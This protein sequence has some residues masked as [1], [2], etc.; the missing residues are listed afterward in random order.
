MAAFCP[1]RWPKQK[2]RWNNS[3]LLLIEIIGSSSRAL[4]LGPGPLRSGRDSFPFI[5]LKCC[6]RLVGNAVGTRTGAGNKPSNVSGL[7]S[8]FL[9]RDHAIRV[10][11][12]GE[13]ISHRPSRRATRKRHPWQSHGTPHDSR[14]RPSP[15]S[16][17]MLRWIR[18]YNRDDSRN[19]STE[20]SLCFGFDRYCRIARRWGQSTV[21]SRRWCSGGPGAA[22][23][24]RHN[25]K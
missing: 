2:P 5:P 6:E 25:N 21:H 9:F 8:P 19:R 3:T 24:E 22:W 12:A 17:S 23:P 15:V 7:P 16:H 14:D 1:S 20:V 10:L 11:L 18:R 13:A 4:S